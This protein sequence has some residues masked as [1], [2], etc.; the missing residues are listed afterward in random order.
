MQ[1]Q[2]GVKF[3]VMGRVQGVG[4]RYFTLTVARK[5]KLCGYVQN[6]ADGSVTGVA[7]G[8]KESLTQLGEYLQEGPPLSKVN[9]VQFEE[10]Q[11]LV[12]TDLEQGEFQIRK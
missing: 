12:L 1:T 10:I 5:L 3:Q 2:C 6:E 4:Y 7:V 9:Q 8:D 11:S